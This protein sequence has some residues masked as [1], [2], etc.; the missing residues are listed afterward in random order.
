MFFEGPEKKV[1]LVV[2]GAPSLRQLGEAFWRRVVVASGAQILS[3][4]HSDD[5]DAY[6]LSESSLFVYDARV[7][8]ITC[9]QTTLAKAAELMMGALEDHTLALMIYERKN[10]HFPEYQHT[11]F[12]D[13]ARTL[14]ALAPGRALRFGAPDSHRL[15]LFHTDAPYTPAAGDVT[16]EVLMHGISAEAAARFHAV[17][18][19]TP[20]GVAA[21]TGIADML[22]GFTLDEHLF[23][24]AGYSLNGLN[25]A[26]YATIHVTPEAIGSYVSFETNLDFRADPSRLI[27]QVVGIF[28]PASF[29]VITFSPAPITAPD[30][31]AHRLRNHVEQI[32][33]CGYHVAFRHYYR[34]QTRP[35]RAFALPL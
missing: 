18:N 1:E 6:L 19:A 11:A 27:R 5:C 31:P 22:P 15:M 25:G 35:G 13:D 26:A 2:E 33:D 20:E 28:E 32:L 34:P 24:P 9:G 17:P 23:E 21:R 3:Q 30:L 14:H 16:L 29:D 7:I 8:M 12:I 4:I 10:E